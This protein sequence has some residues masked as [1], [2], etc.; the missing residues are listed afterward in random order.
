LAH[1]NQRRFFAPARPVKLLL[2]P[3]PAHEG[4]ALNGQVLRAI[5]GII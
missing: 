5:G 1:H 4:D 2:A 3:A